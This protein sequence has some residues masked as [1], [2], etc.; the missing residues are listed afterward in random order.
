MN[1]WIRCYVRSDGNMTR[2]AATDCRKKDSDILY[3]CPGMP[4][5]IRIVEKAPGEFQIT[6][7]EPTRLGDNTFIIHYF[8]DEEFVDIHEVIKKYMKKP[9]AIVEVKEVKKV[10]KEGKK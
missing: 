5:V 6:S 9:Q 10:K 3:S 2:G 8:D 4:Y 1:Q 7:F